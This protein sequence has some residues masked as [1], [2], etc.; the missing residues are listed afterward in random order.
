M[1]QNKICKRND[2]PKNKLQNRI[3]S[4]ENDEQKERSVQVVGKK[5]RKQ[6]KSMM[7]MSLMEEAHHMGHRQYI[8]RERERDMISSYIIIVVQ[9]NQVNWRQRN[10][11]TS[12]H[13]NM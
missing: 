8:Y 10:I 11:V 9:S 7:R 2:E 12:L 1:I 4:K 6:A 5:M 3:W 13:T